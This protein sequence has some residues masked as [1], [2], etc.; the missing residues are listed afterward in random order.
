LSDKP[1]S[2]PSYKDCCNKEITE[3]IPVAGVVR[4]EIQLDG[5]IS[6]FLPETVGRV[7]L[8]I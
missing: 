1:R 6:C 7:T 5:S 4:D 3:L 8:K 2:L